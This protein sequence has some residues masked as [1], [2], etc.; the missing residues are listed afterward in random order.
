MLLKQYEKI[1]VREFDLDEF[2]Y[3]LGVKD[4]IYPQFKH[5]RT[6]VINQAK[7]ELDKKDKQG[8]FISDITF[9]FEPIKKGRSIQR[10]R[11]II[12]KNKL[13]KT[14]PESMM[15]C[16]QQPEAIEQSEQIKNTDEFKVMR[17]LGIAEK[18]IVSILGKYSVETIKEKL[19]LTAETVRKNPIG[20]FI[21]ALEE[22][23]P[24]LFNTN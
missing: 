14:I 3:N 7:K 24:G 11:F 22:D 8:D 5:F 4:T 19:E 18:K 6:R 13:K 20:F 16:S 23:Y 21:K 15:T 17:A 1:G 12:I 2:R 9:N 10:L